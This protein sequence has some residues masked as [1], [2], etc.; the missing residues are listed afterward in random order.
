MPARNAE[1]FVAEA[2]ESILLQTFDDFELVVLDDAS[3][4]A[5]RTILEQYTDDRRVRIVDGP[6]AGLTPALNAVCTAARGELLAR[7]DAD[8]I[9]LPRRL[10][11]QVARLDDPELAAVGGAVE[12]LDSRGVVV[13]I[14]RYPIEPEAVAATLM[15]Y[16]CLPH[17]AVT[18]RRSAFEA[19]GGYR[20]PYAE[21]YDLW[22]RMAERWQ[23]ANLTQSVVRLRSHG[24]RFSLRHVETQAIGALLVRRAAAERRSG[25]ED[26]LAPQ[27]APTR[28]LARSLGSSDAEIDDAI[29]DAFA[30]VAAQEPASADELVARAA[31]LTRVDAE[32]VRVAAALRAAGQRA[33]LR[34]AGLVAR[35]PLRA[36]GELRRIRRMRPQGR[37]E[38]S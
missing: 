38:R 32:G 22:L 9:A 19:C 7:M 36:T 6:G 35:H 34:I 17:G 29:V 27:S 4:D 10:E 8:D 30:T 12:L 13:G 31:A 23:L 37:V 1:P 25:R 3:T 18:M 20:L 26:K 2:V 28:E 15:T 5:T 21:D 16:N 33:P 24:A 14:A 11:H